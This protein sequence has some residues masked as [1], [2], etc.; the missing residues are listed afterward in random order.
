MDR[1]EALKLLTGGKDG[2][3]E[4]NRRRVE[5]D[6]IPSLDRARL[7][8]ANLSG[9]YLGGARLVR[10]RLLWA[11]LDSALLV[12]AR[13]DGARL[14]SA[15]LRGVRF[16]GTRL[17]GAR[18]HG[19]NLSGALLDGARLD[20]ARLGNTV[21]TNVDLSQT[22]GLDKVVHDRPST[23]GIETLFL[24]KGK[25][26]E[27]FLRGCGVPASLIAYLPSLIG[28]MSPIEFYSCFIS[29]SSQDE[30]F[31]TRLHSRMVQEK[32]R[33]WYAPEDMRGGR[34]SIDQ[35]DQAIR[36]HDKLLLVLSEAS[37]SSDW[38]RHEVIRAIE[39][40]KAEKRQVLFPISLVGFDAI[41]EWT[42][43]D[44]DLGRDLAK[45]VRAYHVPDFS[46]WKEHDAFEEG[47][48][49]LLRDLNR[50]DTIPS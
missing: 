37:M 13:L 31:A 27:V 50:E 3:S 49:K 16:H 45:V 25:I 2:I 18:L 48:K 33:V 24:S 43:F 9:A 46:K 14:D 42:A 5:G 47:F 32:L 20:R 7:D 34:K 28:A 17:D 38:V 10:A 44:S 4:W 39:R 15:D 30:D 36:I 11:R 12:R 23:V 21:L 8:G 6:E 40:E 1:D 22:Q 26:P 19:A 35:I 29:H 41:K